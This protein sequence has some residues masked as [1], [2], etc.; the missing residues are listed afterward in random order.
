MNVLIGCTENS[1]P[2]S[3]SRPYAQN[4]SWS[5][6]NKL[7]S[8]AQLKTTNYLWY[9]LCLFIILIL[10]F[11][12]ICIVKHNFIYFFDKCACDDT[13]FYN[14]QKYPKYFCLAPLFLSA[15]ICS[16]KI[17]TKFSFILK[18]QL[19]IIFMFFLCSET[20]VRFTDFRYFGSSINSSPFIV[21]DS[22][23]STLLFTVSCWLEHGCKWK[24]HTGQKANLSSGTF[25][26]GLLL[27]FHSC[28]VLV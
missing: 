27:L 21:P 19:G 26:F 5:T 7:Q 1:Y 20:S 10:F 18:C 22:T 15:D 11:L 23:G 24:V 16:R 12:L 9:L 17:L 3:Q 13:W 8:F 4:W 6:G 28:L 25:F 2:H 14:Y